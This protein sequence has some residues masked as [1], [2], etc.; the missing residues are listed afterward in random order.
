MKYTAA[1]LIPSLIFVSVEYVQK[2]KK[3]IIPIIQLKKGLLIIGNSLFIISIITIIMQ[4]ALL[5]YFTGFTTDGILE[6]EYIRTLSNFSFI[7]R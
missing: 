6:I 3:N 1:L 7:G 5:E 4:E 2:Q